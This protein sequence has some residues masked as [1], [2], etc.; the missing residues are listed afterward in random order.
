MFSGKL[1]GMVVRTIDEVM[2]HID[3]LR[4]ARAGSR[5][6]I[7]IT[8]APGSGKSTLS[9]LI[10]ERLVARDGPGTCVV[11]PMDGFHLS[12]HVLTDLGR[13]N[14]KGAIDTFDADGYVALLERLRRRDEPIVYAPT[15]L[16]GLEEAIAGS[17]A[18][19]R[20]SDFVIT[21][22]NYLLSDA[23]PWNRVGGLVDA[24]FFVETPRDIRIE[25]LTQRHVLFGMDRAAAEAWA[26]GPDEANA[27][28]VAATRDRA[29]AVVSLD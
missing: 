10:V 22:G 11:V 12:N 5:Q 25:R 3:A 14:R 24:S 26:N 16:R 21:E 2:A 15:Y 17:I 7:A 18:V 29:D 20:E 6:I 4:D 27:L 9:D 19:P 1:G 28:L 8:G 23:E 13:L